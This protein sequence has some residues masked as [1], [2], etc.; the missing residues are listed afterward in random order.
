MFRSIEGV[1]KV[2]K[3][4]V[5]VGTAADS[6]FCGSDKYLLTETG[7]PWRTSAASQGFY[8][9]ACAMGKSMLN[10]L[11]DRKLNMASRMSTGRGSLGIL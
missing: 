4:F 11:A 2:S 10:I 6:R 9:F 7:K 8:E 3:A 1:Y 5:Q